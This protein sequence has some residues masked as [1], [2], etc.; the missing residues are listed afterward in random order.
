MLSDL[1]ARGLIP[2]GRA[3]IPGMGRGYDVTSL[4]SPERVVYGVDIVEVKKS[5]DKQYIYIYIYRYVLL[6]RRVCEY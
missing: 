4:A 5:T 3:L 1:L 2:Q 6:I